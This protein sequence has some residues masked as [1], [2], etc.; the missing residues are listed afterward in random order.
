MVKI[1]YSDYL[2]LCGSQKDYQSC[3]QEEYE[4]T[5]IHISVFTYL[6][7]VVLALVGYVKDRLATIGIGRIVSLKDSP[8]HKV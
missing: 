2:L 6:C 3:Y 7:Y 1:F 4:E 8:K 5:P